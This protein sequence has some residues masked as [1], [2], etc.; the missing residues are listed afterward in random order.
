M[1]M[2]IIYA[3]WWTSIY[4]SFSPYGLNICA[5]LMWILKCEH[6]VLLCMY[7]YMTGLF[8]LKFF[9]PPLMIVCTHKCLFVNVNLWFLFACVEFICAYVCTYTAH[10]YDIYINDW[11]LYICCLYKSLCVCVWCRGAR[12]HPHHEYVE[13]YKHVCK[14]MH[15]Q[16]GALAK[17]YLHIHNS[18]THTPAHTFELWYRR[19]WGWLSL[20]SP[21][22]RL[23]LDNSK[24]TELPSHVFWGLSSLRS[25]LCL[26]ER[27]RVWVCHTNTQTWMSDTQMT[28]FE[29]Q[30]SVFERACACFRARQ[31]SIAH[32]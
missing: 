24:L 11:Q 12:A 13:K 25:L 22:S 20:V 27:K 31:M 30:S 10:V 18:H 3:F 19:V 7:V 5:S 28:Y 29:M 8:L 2:Y 14:H 32:V 21:L 1:Y 9:F 26:R 6:I 4:F 17:D 23:Y 16:T 15:G